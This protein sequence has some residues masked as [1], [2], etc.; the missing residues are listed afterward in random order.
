MC[1]IPVRALLPPGAE[2]ELFIGGAGVARGYLGRPELTAERF[3]PDPFGPGRLY[4]TG[5]R[6]RWR[7]DGN[8]EFLGR[9][10]DQMKINGVRVEP[11]EIEAALLAL[12][13]IA[14]A[15]VDAPR[16]CRR[17]AAGSPRISSRST[18]AVPE[19]ANV[20][21]ALERQLPRHMVALI[22]CLARRYADDA[23]RQARPQGAAG[24]AARG[25]GVSRRTTR[26]R[27]SWSARSPES[28]KMCCNCHRSASRADFF[29]LGGDSLALLSL[30]AAIE[31]R[32]GRRLTVDVLTGGLTIA[33]LAQLLAETNR[34][35]RRW[36]RSWRFSRS[37]IF[38]RSSV[39]TASAATCCTCTVSPCIWGR[40]VPFSVSAGLQNLASLTPSVRSPRVTS[41][42][43]CL[44]NPRGRSISGAT[45]SARWSPTRWR[46]Q[47]DEA[48]T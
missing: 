2:G 16:G 30:F 24:A 45:R 17:A 48:R 44:I 20:R 46:V 26:Q 25:N 11:G 34:R 37:G 1:W 5:D 23:E 42:R 32:F 4:R 8:L 33:G 12:P 36:I 35:R 6:V 29:E 14:A 41:P 39:F 18:G 43:C 21:A 19:T 31:T 9:A 10:D 47:L 22:V 38:R 15:V 27:P 3:L 13:G 28:G 7:P 40:I